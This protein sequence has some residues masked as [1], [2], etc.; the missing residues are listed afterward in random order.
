MSLSLKQVQDVCYGSAA[1]GR[2]SPWGWGGNACKYLTHEMVG[3][4]YKPLCLKLA[5]G[6]LEKKKKDGLLPHNFSKLPDN[7]SGYK[8]MKYIEQGYDVV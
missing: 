2:N 6:V 4:D 1:Q 3:K 8:Y 7:C 5:P